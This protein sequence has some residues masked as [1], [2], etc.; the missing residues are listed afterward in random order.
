MQYVCSNPDCQRLVRLSSTRDPRPRR[1][2]C[3]HCGLQGTLQAEP[4]NLCA[5]CGRRRPAHTMETL[6]LGT[7]RWA[8]PGS[9]AD[10]V[11]SFSNPVQICGRRAHGVR[12]TDAAEAAATPTETARQ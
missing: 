2:H 3:P 12:E 1:A 10:L 11:G 7:Y 8:V 5:I 6:P 9:G 4:K